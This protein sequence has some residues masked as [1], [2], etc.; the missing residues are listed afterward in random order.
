LFDGAAGGVSSSKK[1]LLFEK[2][3]KNFCSFDVSGAPAPTPYLQKFFGSFLQKTTASSLPFRAARPLQV[4]AAAGLTLDGA[5]PAQWGA[6]VR[7]I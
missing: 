1:A 3:S 4:D 6:T 2:R 5:L 7:C